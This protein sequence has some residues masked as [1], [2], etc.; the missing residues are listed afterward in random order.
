MQSPATAQPTPVLSIPSTF[1]HVWLYCLLRSAFRHFLVTPVIFYSCMFPPPSLL[2]LLL[3]V[4]SINVSQ[5]HAQAGWSVQWR[6][7]SGDPRSLFQ[8]AGCQVKKGEKRQ[9]E[10]K[11]SLAKHSR[12]PVSSFG[13][14][15]FWIF[16][17][18]T[19]ICLFLLCIAVIFYLTRCVL[20][21]H[22]LVKVDF[23][24]WFVHSCSLYFHQA[25][26]HL[27][28]YSSQ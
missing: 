11:C 9:C 8:F 2:T 15:I 6:R 14:F 25:F 10:I 17:S 7:A 26:V 18:C 22:V 21:F 16:E 20:P 19:C 28:S 5:R 24:D 1:C 4:S 12:E 23:T 3:P 13:S 27:W